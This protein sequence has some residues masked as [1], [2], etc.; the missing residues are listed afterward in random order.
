MSPQ[1]HTKPHTTDP[2]CY[3]LRIL[4]LSTLSPSDSPI[5]WWISL[6]NTYD[7]PSMQSGWI[8]GS[9]GKEYSGKI[10]CFSFT[11]VMWP[12]CLLVLLSNTPSAL[13]KHLKSISENRNLFNLLA[14][15]YQI[16]EFSALLS[17][18]SIRSVVS[19]RF[20]HHMW[21]IMLLDAAITLE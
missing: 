14:L 10:T 15:T 5:D 2:P 11:H 21:G 12:L 7:T 1:Q 4:P 13:H 9:K 20:V 3:M 19:V 18:M 8:Y 17:Q 16:Y 6:L